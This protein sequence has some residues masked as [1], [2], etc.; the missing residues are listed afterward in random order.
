MILVLGGTSEARELILLCVQHGIPVMY[1]TT[2]RIMDEFAP[3][4]E[5]RVG[6]L[7]PQT[8]QALIIE[9]RIASVVDATHPFAINI[10]R[11]A[12]DVCNRTKT[13]YLRLERE[14][15][16]QPAICRH[17][18]QIET[19]EEA[20]SLACETSGGILSV[21]GVRK[22]PELV[23]HLGNRKSDLFARVLPVVKSIATCDQLGIRPSHI[24]GMRG[25]FSAEFD[26]LLIREFGITTMIAKES[27]DRGGLTAKITACENTGCK[28]L[29][30]VRPAIQY[31]YQVSTPV[32]C[33]AWLKAHLKNL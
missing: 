4:V 23:T 7:S 32:K 1:T 27:G 5:C 29:L 13:P 16:A 17:V 12:M 24:I 22:L 14:T 28:L 2:T 26:G 15:L 30:I 10:S 21:I 8:F 31:P 3:T 18:H 19:V 9:R 33:M 6:Q 25:P 11:L 20:A